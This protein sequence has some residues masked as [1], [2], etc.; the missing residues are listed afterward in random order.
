MSDLRRLLLTFFVALLAV[1]GA[2]ADTVTMT[3]VTK[4]SQTIGTTT[5]YWVVIEGTFTSDMLPDNVRPQRLTGSPAQWSDW[6]Y[7]NVINYNANTRS[8]TFSSTSASTVVPGPNTIRV[9]LKYGAT[10]GA[11]SADQNNTFP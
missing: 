4:K 1:G 11:A 3:K 7:T 8:G 9:Q 5:Y 6:G 10:E 2:N